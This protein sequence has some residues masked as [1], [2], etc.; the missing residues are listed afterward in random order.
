MLLLLG[1]ANVANLLIFRAARREHEIAIRKALGASR[2]RLM[3]LQMMESW[4]LSVAGATLGL[5]LA[6]YLK[7]L[8]EQLLFPRPPG[9]SFTVPMDMRVL[10]LTVAVALATGTLAALAPG[11]LVTRTRG[12]AALGR[13]TVTWSRAP[14]LRGSLA[15]L[16]LALSLTLLISALLL[17]STLR[18][19]RAV[20]LGF[21]PDRC[22]RRDVQPR[23]ARV[24]Q[25]P[26][27]GVSPGSAARPP[28]DRR[29]R[30]GQPRRHARRSARA[31]GF[32]V[33]PPGGDRDRPLRVA[34]NG[35]S[36]SYFRL[37]SI[38]IVRGRA[39]TLGEALRYRRAW[40]ADRERNA[41]A[42]VVPHRRRR[43]ADRAARGERG[44]P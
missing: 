32:G 27:P 39:F 22:E 21:D 34:A 16:Q 41:C 23:R 29:V 20:D 36:D 31:R 43:R 24:R 38:P 7:Q 40:A 9:M 8:I 42:A 37:L 4:L 11:W 18:N 19:L 2:S 35:V 13:A 1:C 17:V 33:I 10:G 12:L 25:P 3:Q 28:G 26:R 6:V 30:N 5:A 44:T 15:V 14:K